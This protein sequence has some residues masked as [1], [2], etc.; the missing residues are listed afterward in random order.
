MTNRSVGTENPLYEKLCTRFSYDGM[1]VG[2][3]MLAR[4]KEQ[5][6]L[7]GSPAA[8]LC[9]VTAESTIT[10]AN[11][12]PRGGAAEIALRRPARPAFSWSRINPSAALA[13]A[14]AFFIIAY[15]FVAGISHHSDFTPPDVITASAVEID[16]TESTDSVLQN[17]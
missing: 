16:P 2:E 17:P 1:T 8:N 15:L 13:V 10:R 12:L 6:P 14:L 7:C 4:A 3:M 5:A 9:D 11:F